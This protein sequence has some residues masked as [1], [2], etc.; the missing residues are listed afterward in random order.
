MDTLKKHS[1]D[2]VRWVFDDFY[3]SP[4][5][6]RKDKSLSGIW[7]WFNPN[8]TI[9]INDDFYL[10]PTLYEKWKRKSSNSKNKNTAVEFLEFL[11]DNK[12]ILYREQLKGK[13]TEHWIS[14][15]KKREKM[16]DDQVWE[17]YKN[18]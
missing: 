17:K 9:N 4:M 3:K 2:F 5:N 6:V 12:I 1:L 18:K 11:A 8:A 15:N 10:T 7:M 13:T 14:L 16:S